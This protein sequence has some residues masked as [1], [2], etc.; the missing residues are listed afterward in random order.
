M[1]KGSVREFA[2]SRS[3]AWYILIVCSLLYAV[4]YMDRQVLAI[5]TEYIKSDLQLSDSL[6]G[7]IQTIFF[8]GMAAFSFP[9]AYLVDRYSRKKMIS[10]MALLWSLFTFL[11]GL[12]KSFLSILIPRT[13]VGIGE[14][15]FTSGGTPLIAAAFPKESRGM[16]MGVFNLAIPV[17]SGLGMVL[18]GA[19]AKSFG[20]RSSFYIF[21][22]PGVILGVLAL[23]MK[24]YKTVRHID[25]SGRRISFMRSAVSLFRIPTLKWIY[26]GYAMQNLM[27]FSFLTWGPAYVMRSLNVD[28]KRAGILVGVVA[29]MAIVGSILG[30][31]AADAWQRR[32]KRGRMLTA[33]LGLA[34]ATLFFVF[35]LCFDLAGAGYIF[36]ALFGVFM[37]VPL[38]GIAAITQDVAPP[39]LK[40]VSWGMNAFCC[41]VLGGGWAPLLVGLVSDRLGGGV[42]GLKVGLFIAGL[43]GLAGALCYWIGSGHYPS[44]L[45]RVESMVVE[46]EG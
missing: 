13:F 33:V 43:G 21:A 6:I 19:I 11:T 41:Y 3:G 4:N 15:G 39:S 29:L 40:G 2:V 5:N 42:Y 22:V 27:A 45:E 24:D 32:N 36:C 14:A 18:G 20:W 31:V 8:M 44:D 17:G 25:E 9:T 1:D 16:A 37:T 23:L 38:P 7:V 35:T 34:A 10:I 46:A 26:I 12:G 30:G 28:A